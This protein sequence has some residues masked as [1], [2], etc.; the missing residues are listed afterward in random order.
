MISASQKNWWDDDGVAVPVFPPVP[1]SDPDSLLQDALDHLALILAD[2]RRHGEPDRPKLLA[3]DRLRL[4]LSGRR[5]ARAF[6]TDAA[7]DRLC[8]HTALR[9]LDSREREDW[10]PQT[11]DRFKRVEQALAQALQQLPTAVPPAAP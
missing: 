8:F 7:A 11:W 2:E 3:L 9:Q 1:K 10:A 5:Y 6:A 4:D